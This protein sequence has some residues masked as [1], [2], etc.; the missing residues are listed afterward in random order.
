ELYLPDTIESE[1]VQIHKQQGTKGLLQVMK[2]SLSKGMKNKWNQVK[3]VTLGHGRAGKTT[4][5]TALHSPPKFFHRVWNRFHSGKKIES[6]EGVDID[7]EELQIKD[8]QK[9]VIF[10]TWDFAGQ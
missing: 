5:L 9:E 8:P 10:T 1:L 6:T 3:V 2:D 4:L 7:N